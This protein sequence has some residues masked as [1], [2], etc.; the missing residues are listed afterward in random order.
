MTSRIITFRL[1]TKSA[2]GQIWQQMEAEGWKAKQ[3]VE[4]AVLAVGE[5]IPPKDNLD[6]RTRQELN[7]VVSRLETLV[8]ALTTGA[9]I[10][11]QS[12]RES[13]DALNPQFVEAMKRAA[14][15]A[16]RPK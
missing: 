4:Y 12:E 9:P 6:E 11:A 2:F 16:Y 7:R 10:P 5:Q 14:R 15:P 3:I 1:N 8:N 13:G